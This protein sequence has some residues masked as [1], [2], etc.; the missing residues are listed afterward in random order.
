M[1]PVPRRLSRLIT[2]VVLLCL[3]CLST[4]AADLTPS[5]ECLPDETAVMVRAPQAEAFLNALRARTRFGAVG[6]GADRI[7][8]VQDLLV[9]QFK[10]E[11]AE[12]QLASLEEELAK[13]DLKPED[14]QAVFKGDLGFGI[15]VQPRQ[16][17]RKPLVIT[18]AW[19]EP[20]T[21][22]AER[23]FAAAKRSLEE[24]QAADPEN[25]PKRIDLEM[26]GHEVLWVVD[27][28]MAPD[29]GGL[30]GIDL[31][32]E[33]GLQQRIEERIRNAKPV[34]VGETHVF[35]TRVAGRLLAGFPAPFRRD[36]GQRAEADAAD[37]DWGQE[38]G[39]EEAKGVFE[40]FLAAH[41]AGNE[42]RLA[43]IFR[44]PGVQETLPAGL[45]LVEILV[46]PR[47]FI[48][49]YAADDADA[50]RRLASLGLAD[51]GPFAWRQSFD[52]GCYHNG[53]FLSLPGPRA[54]LMRML[55]QPCDPAEPPSFV[56]R[57]A[58]DLTQLSLDLGKAF[59][60]VR[61][62][63]VADGVEET[64][65][66]F[67]ALE[68]QT[69]GWLGV[70]LPKLLT[71][72]GT[73]HWII[74]YPA[75]IAEAVAAGRKAR[76]GGERFDVNGANPAAFVWQ[77]ADEEPFV[78]ILQRLAPM[79]GG[80]LRE[81]Q[82]F[83]GIRLPNDAAAYVGRNHLVLA[84]GA[85]SLDKTLTGIRNPP[86]GDAS[87]RESAVMQR[88]GQLLPLGP[89]RIFNLSDAS[90]TGGTLGNLR[91]LVAS[92]DADDVPADYRDLLAA[93]QNV[94]PSAEEMEGMFGVGTG[95]MRTT[96][97]GIAI[98]AV[99]EMPAP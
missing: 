7:R 37:R 25:A 31:E 42:S 22:V 44:L 96:D 12:D 57:E 75:K 13:H 39:A 58:V 69:L 82:G 15:V 90:R 16:D 53:L 89:A 6:L 29:L 63:A 67:N 88:A 78:K 71:S 23:M 30:E 87:L 61:E 94:L 83:R 36:G 95:T 85:D 8:K 98:R 81:E 48:R 46:D 49:A 65:N 17:G 45:P 74:S 41:A 33:E 77:V 50:M 47:I 72:L 5:W 14:L 28:L 52:Q 43:G 1:P 91:E 27:R 35:L 21:D 70:E 64:A 73:R 20:G 24:T 76:E 84:V 99:W 18:L 34:Q 56:S 40:R 79:A 97:D 11:G 32:D 3:V 54:G 38:G 68:A 2:G 60:T 4:R 55:D 59:E 92:L 66:V 80:E 51:V 9:A 10:R 86:T 93:V 26:A 62:F 19:L